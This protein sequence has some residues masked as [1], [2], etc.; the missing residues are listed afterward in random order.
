MDLSVQHCLAFF[1]LFKG[2]REAV[3]AVLLEVALWARLAAVCPALGTCVDGSV[4]CAVRAATVPSAAGRE[5]E[6]PFFSARSPAA[7]PVSAP[8]GGTAVQV[9]TAVLFGPE[10]SIG[11]F[12]QAAPPLSPWEHAGPGPA[13]ETDA[14]PPPIPRDS[15][16]VDASLLLR[17][18]VDS[19]AVAP[20]ATWP[21]PAGGRLRTPGSPSGS[22]QSA[23]PRGCARPGLLKTEAWERVP[24]EEP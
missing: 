19:P 18:S 13:L 22:P 8:G 10:R 17:K 24:E 6:L 4:G 23:G 16:S 20:G 7:R 9:G 14:R 5:Q 11:R 3:R 15:A 2:R 12:R 21:R 1:P